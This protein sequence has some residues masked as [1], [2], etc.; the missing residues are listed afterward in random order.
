MRYIVDG[1]VRGLQAGVAAPEQR[2]HIG[3]NQRIRQPIKDG[4]ALD[5]AQVKRTRNV[6]I[7]DLLAGMERADTSL[8][9]VFEGHKFHRSFRPK[10]NAAGKQKF[11]E[12]E[13]GC[14]DGP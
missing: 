7:D 11:S 14:P 10:W 2:P 13:F 9:A 6:Q 5:I 1:F 12:E 8:R 4:F 3:W